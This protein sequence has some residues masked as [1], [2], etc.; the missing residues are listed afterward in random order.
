MESYWPLKFMTPYMASLPKKGTEQFIIDRI[1]TLLEDQQLVNKKTSKGLN[2]F[3]TTDVSEKILEQEPSTEEPIVI[4]LETPK[5]PRN[6]VDNYMISI[7]NKLN[8]QFTALN[9]FMM[10]ELWEIKKHVNIISDLKNITKCQV[11]NGESEGEVSVLM[12]EVKILREENGNKHVI[13]KTLLVNQKS[14]MQD[15]TNYSLHKNSKKFNHH[16]TNNSTETRKDDEQWKIVKN[17]PPSILTANN[18]KSSVT[19]SN[20][21]NDLEF[22]TSYMPLKENNQANTSTTHIN[23]LQTPIVQ[24]TSDQQI[25]NKRPHPVINQHPDRERFYQK[26]HNNGSFDRTTPHKPHKSITILSDSIPK[27]IRVREFNNCISNGY[28]KFKSFPGANVAHLNYYSNPTLTEEKPN[29]VVIHVGINNL[30]SAESNTMSDDDIAD[31]II[32]LGVKCVQ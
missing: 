22:N 8:A 7:E 12:D 5:A 6:L 19:L 16:D 11:K 31:E 23:N 20:R 18:N 27:G 13:I 3:Y 14:L 25:T 24:R 2:S 10:N 26:Q 9:F 1:D 15:D 29:V 28:A 30:L 21:F 4:S 17:G 32:N